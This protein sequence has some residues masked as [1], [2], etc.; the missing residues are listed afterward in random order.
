MSDKTCQH[1]GGI[2]GLRCPWVKALEYH[3]DG[4]LK[5]VEFFESKDSWQKWTVG[6]FQSP[7]QEKL[8]SPQ[9]SRGADHDE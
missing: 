2:H 9:P 6:Q 3:P 1:C 7:S 4:T 8:L 5:R